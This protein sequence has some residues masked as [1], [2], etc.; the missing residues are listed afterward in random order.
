MEGTRELVEKITAEFIK[1][2]P[3]HVDFPVGLV[4]ISHMEGVLKGLQV[5][6]RVAGICIKEHG[7]IPHDQTLWSLKDAAQELS[8][9]ILS[10]VPG[11]LDFSHDVSKALYA[12][13]VNSNPGLQREIQKILNKVPP[14]DLPKV[15]L[16][17]RLEKV[18]G[19]CF[20]KCAGKRG[21]QEPC[22]WKRTIPHGHR[23]DGICVDYLC[24]H[25][26]RS[27]K[28]KNQHLN[29]TVKE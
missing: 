1:T 6:M 29:I 8:E 12:D 7:M 27:W 2:C 4:R 23:K 13:M 18:H 21:C 20:A 15:G 14:S 16:E 3:T 10:K 5:G 11:D 28:F 25:H 17:R 24:E 19:S 9:F 26:M 22:I